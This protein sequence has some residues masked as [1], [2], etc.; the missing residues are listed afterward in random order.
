MTA[1]PDLQALPELPLDDEG[2]VF[3]APWEARAFALAVRLREQGHFTWHEW[4]EQLGGTIAAAR[5]ADDPNHGKSY[6][7]LWLACLET[8]ARDKGLV[9]SELLAEHKQ[10]AHEAQQRLHAHRD[11]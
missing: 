4:A 6:Y 1:I 10:Q 3:E 2:P 5:S 9:T 8:I 11:H 7:E